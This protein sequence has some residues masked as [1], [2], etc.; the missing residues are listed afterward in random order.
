[1]LR[2]RPINAYWRSAGS[3]TLSARRWSG[4]FSLPTP[5]PSPSASTTPSRRSGS[6]ASLPT[7]ANGSALGHTCFEASTYP[8]VTL[9]SEAS[10]PPRRL[11]IMVTERALLP[12]NYGYRPKGGNRDTHEHSRIPRRAADPLPLGLARPAQSPAG[13]GGGDHPVS[14]Q[15]RHPA[16]SGDPAG[17]GRPRA[18]RTP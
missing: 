2:R 4:N 9:T 7:G 5:P 1:M 10:R 16:P 3:A 18:R 11:K 12:Q 15:G 6:S 17:A 13:R 14:P 8:T